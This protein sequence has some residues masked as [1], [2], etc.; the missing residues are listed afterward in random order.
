MGPSDG[1]I[2]FD[3]LEEHRL[4]GITDAVDVL[5]GVHDVAA[6]RGDEPGRGRDDARLVGAREQQ[7]R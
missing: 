2:E 1:Q 5:F 6:C 7:D 4:A 3:P